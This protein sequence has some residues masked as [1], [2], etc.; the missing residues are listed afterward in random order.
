MYQYEKRLDCHA[1]GQEIKRRRKAKGWTQIC[2]SGWSLVCD[3]GAEV[4]GLRFWRCVPRFFRLA[5]TDAWLYR[6]GSK[7]TFSPSDFRIMV[8]FSPS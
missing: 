1:L 8:T 3:S 4:Y 5:L 2:W 7:T 6:Q